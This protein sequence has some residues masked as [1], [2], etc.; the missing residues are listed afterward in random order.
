VSP[1]RWVVI[2]YVGLGGAA[3]SIVRYA[4]SVTLQS[5][6]GTGFPVATFSINVVG[7]FLL[8]ALMGYFSEE[9]TTAPEV[10]LLLTSGFCGGFTTFSTFS[11]E[12]FRLFRDGEQLRGV[13]YV[14]LSALVSLIAVAVGFALTRAAIGLRRG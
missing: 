4:L 6:A 1:F 9:A 13:A 11:W 14:G 3:G 5:R 12:A 7:S 10:Q 8:G 2:A